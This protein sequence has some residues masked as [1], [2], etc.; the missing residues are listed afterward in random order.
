MLPGPGVASG[1]AAAV[2]RVAFP[3]PGF[4]RRLC[5]GCGRGVLVA[6]FSCVRVQ[7]HAAC[8]V[9]LRAV[10]CCSL[11]CVHRS[12]VHWVLPAVA[13]C[14]GPCQCAF[15]LCCCWSA[16][17][18]RFSVLECAFWGFPLLF[19]LLFPPLRVFITHSAA[20]QRCGATSQSTCLEKVNVFDVGRSKKVCTSRCLMIE[21]VT[22]LKG[23]KKTIMDVKAGGSAHLCMP[24]H[25]ASLSHMM[26]SRQATHGRHQ[27]YPQGWQVLRDSP[28]SVVIQGSRKILHSSHTY[29]AS[30]AVMYESCKLS[31]ITR[32]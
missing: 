20:E 16:P 8:C 2:C 1:L 31:Y 12:S 27:N 25:R 6:S 26:S 24:P 19:A 13:G 18:D 4:A 23:R 30:S 5:G 14:F 10:G 21:K 3:A 15:V 17:P 28:R 11:C 22:S 7:S 9:A 32:L 29:S